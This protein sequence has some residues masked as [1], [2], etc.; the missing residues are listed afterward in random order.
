MAEWDEISLAQAGTWLSGGTPK[1]SEENF[2]GGEIPW[3][4]AASL[5]DFYIESSDR[6]VTKLGAANGTRL[7]PPGT[8]L[9][10]VRGMSLK[11]EFRM[12]ITQKTVAFGQDCKAIIPSQDILP[13]FLAYAL[14]A[15]TEEVLG[16]VD[17]A[18]HGTG[19]L[20]TERIEKLAIILP[21]SLDEQKA[22]IAPLKAL[23]DKIAVN[24]R[25]AA[26]AEELILAVASGKRWT[27]RVRLDE[28]CIL[29]KTQVSPAGMTNTQVDHYSLPAF[30][31]GK[32]SERVPP[33]S[34]KSNKFLI[35][36]PSVLLSKLNPNIPRVWNVEPHPGVPALAS[37]EFLVLVPR[38]GLS[39]HELWAVTAEQEFLD[40][41]A[42][43]VT[44]T[45]KSHQR[46]R[47]DEVLAS[48]VVDPREF[49]DV[50]LAIQDLAR[51]VAAMRRESRTL[52][53]L[54][55][56][57]LPQLMSGRLRVRDAEKIIEDA[58]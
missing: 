9:F 7:V 43:K 57:L 50:R 18:G 45:S 48:Q 4:S 13:L 23:D 17:E 39:P 54:R 58:T 30:D 29:S 16:M 49:G 47:P 25:I 1:T 52:A 8:L 19:R 34:I 3:I 22:T 11:S 24:E 56:T 20:Q 26:T 51:S 33:E 31:A 14:K 37:T 12:G 41:L 15:R 28:I 46:V 36:S 21:R 5:K 55:D 27:S 42:S 6:N 40:T 10:I 2:W 32:S 38:T 35:S 44:G 53:T